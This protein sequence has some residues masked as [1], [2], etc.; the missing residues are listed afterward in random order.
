MDQ[1]GEG[2]NSLWVYQGALW[3][4]QKLE[5]L[6]YELNQRFHD[7]RVQILYPTNGILMW[8]SGSKSYKKHSIDPSNYTN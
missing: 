2:R 5:S 3:A 7:A 8:A 6:F 4:H 1:G